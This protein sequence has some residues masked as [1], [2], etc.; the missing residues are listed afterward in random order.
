M[1]RNNEQRPYQESVM[2]PRELPPMQQG[3]VVVRHTP[4]NRMLSLSQ[5]KSN[6]PAPPPIRGNTKQ[7]HTQQPMRSVQHKPEDRTGLQK[8]LA[9][10]LQKKEQPAPADH[11]R[12]NILTPGQSIKL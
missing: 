10:A 2:P 9:N 1:S 7:Q 5:L 3:D 6:A 12:G 4:P 11:G 8:A